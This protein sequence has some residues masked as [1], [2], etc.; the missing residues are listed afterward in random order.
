MI[1]QLAVLV[2]G[3]ITIAI[4]VILAYMQQ[5]VIGMGLVFMAAGLTY[6]LQFMQITKDMPDKAFGVVM[7]IVIGLVVASAVASAIG[8]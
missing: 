8:L 3:V 5:S 2:Y 7:W 6:L 4:A 1:E